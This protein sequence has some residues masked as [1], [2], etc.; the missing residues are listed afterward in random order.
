MAEVSH[1][2]YCTLCTVHFSFCYNGILS[3]YFALWHS[4]DSL[5]FWAFCCPEVT[6]LFLNQPSWHCNGLGISVHSLPNKIQFI[7]S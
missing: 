7:V 5:V 6:F 3:C 4:Q 2:S 1:G